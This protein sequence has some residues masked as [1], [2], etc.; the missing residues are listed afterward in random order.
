MLR[1][2]HLKQQQEAGDAVSNNNNQIEFNDINQDK[3]NKKTRPSLSIRIYS[4]TKEMIDD[5]IKDG[6]IRDFDGNEVSKIA[7]V[8]E[9]ALAKALN[10]RLVSMSDRQ[11]MIDYGF[12]NVKQ[13]DI[14]RETIKKITDVSVTPEIRKG[15]RLAIIDG[16]VGEFMVNGY[17]NRPE[18]LDA[19]KQKQD[20]IPED[21]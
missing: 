20:E 16:Y 13:L 4:E 17:V 6:L 19:V 10:I 11:F 7:D 2:Q 9:I 5:A 3:I 15:L 18:I 1:K 14:Y 12:D 21:F 8:V